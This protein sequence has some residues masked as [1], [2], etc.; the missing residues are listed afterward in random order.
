MVFKIVCY[1]F[2]IF[3]TIKQRKVFIRRDNSTSFEFK[4]VFFDFPIFT[5]FHRT[6][7]FSNIFR[8]STF[9]V[10]TNKPERVFLKSQR[11]WIVWFAEHRRAAGERKMTI[12]LIFYAASKFFIQLSLGMRW[13]YLPFRLCSF[14]FVV[15]NMQMS[16]AAHPSFQLRAFNWKRPEICHSFPPLSRKNII[17]GLNT[18]QFAFSSPVSTI[19]CSRKNLQRWRMMKRRKIY[20]SNK[21]RVEKDFPCWT[22][23]NIGEKNIQHQHDGKLCLYRHCRHLLDCNIKIQKL[24]MVLEK[25]HPLAMNCF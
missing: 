8:S 19:R 20:K 13:F 10:M 9:I 22:N 24:H 6:K 1:R 5:C 25:W 14:P 17:R 7:S 2:C 18:M 3:R 12:W 21:G 23:I 15:M 16:K 11:T 4:Q